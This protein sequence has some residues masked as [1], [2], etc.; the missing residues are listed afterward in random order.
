MS[1]SLIDIV[2]HSVF[3][4]AESDCSWTVHRKSI[5]ALPLQQWLFKHATILYFTYIA[6]LVK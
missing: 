2:Q 3:Y 1:Y 6:C 5:V 4:V